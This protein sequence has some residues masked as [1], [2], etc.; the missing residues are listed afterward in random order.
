MKVSFDSRDSSLLVVNLF[1]YRIFT[2]LPMLCILSAKSA[3]P[4]VTLVSGVVWVFVI[5]VIARCLSDCADGNILD[6]VQNIFGT[7][8][9][10]I[11]VLIFALYLV[12]SQIFA[13]SEFSKLISLIAFPTS[14]MWFVTIF[15]ILGGV[16]GA[17]S[18]ARSVVRLHGIFMPIVLAVFLL[19]AAS[20][21]L[22]LD[23]ADNF[24]NFPQNMMFSVNDILSQ[25]VFYGDIFIL[26]LLTPTKESRKHMAKK[27]GYSGIVSIALNT[28]FILA[29]AL[30]IPTS[31]AQNG[32]FP[33]YLLMKEV[34]FG[35]FFQR[36]D[37]MIL[38]ICAFSAML[39]LSLNL[40]LLNAVLHRGFRLPQNPIVPMVSGALAF[41]LAISEW[42]FP[43]E[44][45]AN[46][47]YVFSLGGFAILTVI[48]VFAKVR[49][50]LSEKN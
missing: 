43:K 18:N 46:M 29:F 44:F 50:V 28:L 8:G 5:F 40:N 11:V 33:I 30:K 2:Q 41:C 7:V 36:L 14:P 21:V 12:L 15:L 24:A 3:A 27:I 1:V 9:K 31:I 32:Q 17:M 19:L 49:R 45:L 42:I 22:P 26:F 34:Y 25:A 37:A 16:L 4:L 13:L 38:L 6:T 10:T 20:T 48:V 47:L 35:R 39:Y 23:N